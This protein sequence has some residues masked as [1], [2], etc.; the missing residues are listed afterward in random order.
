MT[1]AAW[2]A[3]GSVGAFL[4]AALVYLHLISVRPKIRCFGVKPFHKRDGVWHKHGYI[5]YVTNTGR[6]PATIISAG[7]R[8]GDGHTH[9]AAL[10]PELATQGTAAAFPLIVQPGEIAQT[11][12]SEDQVADATTA[13]FGALEFRWRRGRIDRRFHVA[14][15]PAESDDAT[16]P[17]PDQPVGP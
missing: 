4:I 1:A 6:A 5:I 10:P 7:L 16:A 3:I 14:K 15:M 13:T 2:E 17:L 8:S 11:Y 9:R 12:V